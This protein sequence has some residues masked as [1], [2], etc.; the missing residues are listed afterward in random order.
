MTDL[1]ERRGFETRYYQ[2]AEDS[3]LLATTCL[4]HIGRDDTVLDVGTGSGF[5]A[6]RIRE[7]TGASVVGVDI[8]SVACEVAGNR[9]I[10]VIRGHLASAFRANTFDIV[11]CNPPY[12]PEVSDERRD[13]GL[14]DALWG[15][16][17]GRAVVSALLD[18]VPRVLHQ[19]GE[20]YLLVSSLMNVSAVR[21]L[22]RE[23]E[24]EVS[25]IA[26][27]DSYPDETLSV[28]LL[29]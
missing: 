13:D 7:G 29:R 3:Y 11:V 20:V 12:L 28:L 27:D 25:E 18:D 14:D 24:F 4:D 2:P 5:I 26:R 6:E 15:G 9:G 17:T 1:F 21:R 22:A 19:G 23:S 10:S 16:E 8:N